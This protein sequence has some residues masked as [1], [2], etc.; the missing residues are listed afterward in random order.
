MFE[1]IILGAII[2]FLVLMMGILTSGCTNSKYVIELGALEKQ[3]YLA[4]EW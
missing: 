3:E 4:N 1:K 2:L